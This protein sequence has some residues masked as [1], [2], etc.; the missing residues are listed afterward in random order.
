[1]RDKLYKI[2]NNNYSITYNKSKCPKSDVPFNEIWSAYFQDIFD[3]LTVYRLIGRILLHLYNVSSPNSYL[4][5]VPQLDR[6]ETTTNYVI[7]VR[8]CE[9]IV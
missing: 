6:Y 2:L 8:W 3:P 1:M 9:Y 7:L 5:Q 4:Y